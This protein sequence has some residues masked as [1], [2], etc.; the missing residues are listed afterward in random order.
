MTANIVSIW[1]SCRACHP[2][3]CPLGSPEPLL[4]LAGPE[5]QVSPKKGSEAVLFP[6]LSLQNCPRDGQREAPP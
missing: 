1:V 6:Y 3:W 4:T 5:P 2:P